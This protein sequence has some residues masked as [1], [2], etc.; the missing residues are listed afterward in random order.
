MIKML[1]R[2]RLD[3][4]ALQVICTFLLFNP[5]ESKFPVINVSKYRVSFKCCENQKWNVQ[6]YNSWNFNIIEIKCS[7]FE[8]GN[9]IEKIL[10][11][12][13]IGWDQ[14]L[15]FGLFHNGTIYPGISV[16]GLLNFCL[17]TEFLSFWKSENPWGLIFALT[18]DFSAFQNHKISGNK[19]WPQRRSFE[20]LKIRTTLRIKWITFLISVFKKTTSQVQIKEFYFVWIWFIIKLNLYNMKK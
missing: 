12:V 4:S 18:R 20:L 14:S 15:N 6:M 11:F 7:I 2:A 5:Y 17:N 3:K 19:F 16:L 10:F 13:R 8:F 1:C 9:I